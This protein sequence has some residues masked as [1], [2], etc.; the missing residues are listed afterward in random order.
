ME[1]A[2]EVCGSVRVRKKKIGFRSMKV[3]LRVGE[4]KWE[5]LTTYCCESEERIMNRYWEKLTDFWDISAHMK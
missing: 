2:R 1:S 4:E 3:R 5:L